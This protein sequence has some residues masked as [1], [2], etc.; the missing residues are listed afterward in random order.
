MAAMATD[1]KCCQSSGGD[2]VSMFVQVPASTANRK[3]MV[4]NFFL[5]YT[6]NHS[7]VTP[8]AVVIRYHKI[9]QGS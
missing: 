2:G 9:M 8:N 5:A 4:I 6:A 1:Q 3:Y 7:T